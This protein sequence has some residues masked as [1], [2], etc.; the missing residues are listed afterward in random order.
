MNPFFHIKKKHSTI[1]ANLAKNVAL[2]IY[3]WL[4]LEASRSQLF[5]FKNS[6]FKNSNRSAVSIISVMV[7]DRFKSTTLCF[8]R[9]H[10]S[11]C[12]LTIRPDWREKIRPGVWS[13]L[14]TS[15]W[16]SHFARTKN[17]W[18]RCLSEILLEMYASSRGENT[19]NGTANSADQND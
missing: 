19:L 18:N 6:I 11:D 12:A 7:F 2:Y 4:W 3:I 1:S 15:M 5:F 13:G 10:S 16:K 17:W 8:M 14:I 9:L